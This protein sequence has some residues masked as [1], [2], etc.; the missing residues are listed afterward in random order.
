MKPKITVV[1][2]LKLR[3][4][5]C[6]FCEENKDECIKGSLDLE[7]KYSVPQT[8][9]VRVIKNDEEWGYFSKEKIHK[10]FGVDYKDIKYTK[11]IVNPEIEWEPVVT[12]YETKVITDQ[13]DICTDCIKQL[14]KLVK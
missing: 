12:G 13:A 1:K 8:T 3:N 7:V 9:T 5:F 11:V 2:E 14:A 10:F 4:A 6:N